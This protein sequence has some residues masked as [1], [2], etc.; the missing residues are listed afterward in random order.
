MNI[1]HILI[2]HPVNHSQKV[3]GYFVNKSLLMFLGS[4][5]DHLTTTRKVLLMVQIR[6]S[7]VDMD[8][9]PLFIGFHRYQVVQDFFHQQYDHVGSSTNLS[10]YELVVEPPICNK[11]CFRQYEFIFYNFRGEHKN[12]FETTT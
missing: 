5:Y 4:R 11:K 9:I 1:K 12:L 10:V 8:N 7:P 2:H 3:F 6:R